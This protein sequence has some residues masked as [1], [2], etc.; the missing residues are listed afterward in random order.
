MVKVIEQKKKYNYEDYLKLGDDKRY[1]IIEG[2]LFMM[3]PAPSIIHQR[4][5]RNLGYFLYK[6]ISENNLGEIFYAPCDVVLDKENIVQPDILFISRERM[7]IITE[8]NIQG[9][10]DLII[11]IISE[12]TAYNDL[13]KKK[14]LYSKFKI[15]EY[16]I[17]IPEEKTIEINILKGE[18]FE[19]Y[20]KFKAEVLTSLILK[21]FTLDLN[22]VF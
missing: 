11:E 13:I 21:G 22:K 5:L 8:K 10:P 12:S 4:I 7:N 20:K 14:M 1:E 16:W 18:D 2:E 15:K 19:F 3:T 6:S 17:V 9:S